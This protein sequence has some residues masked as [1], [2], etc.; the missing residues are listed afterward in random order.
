MTSL[1]LADQS[2]AEAPTDGER[3]TLEQSCASIISEI[4]ANTGLSSLELATL[5][6]ASHFSL[7]RWERGDSVPGPEITNTLTAA[8]ASLRRGEP[9]SRLAPVSAF[10]SRGVRRSTSLPLLDP[11]HRTALTDEPGSPI[12]AR[13]KH[14]AFWGA[15]SL[16]EVLA[17]NASASPTLKEAAA[18]G[19][20]AGKNTY[21][22]DAHTYHTKVPPQGIAEV[23]RQYLPAGGLV[24]DPF[25]GSGMTGVAA[26]AVGYDVVLNELSP[27]ASFIADRFTS[28][29]DPAAFS[30]AVA[31]VIDTLSDVRRELYVTDCREC[32]RET[33]L[34]YTVWSYRVSCPA[35]SDE[36][37]LWDHCRSYGRTVRDHKILKEFPCPSCQAVIKKS[38]LARTDAVPVLVGYKCCKRVQVE[39][40][41]SEADLK[42]IKSIEQGEFLVEGFYPET[43]LPAGVNLSQPCKHGLTSIDR[44]YTSRNLSAMSQLWQAIHKVEDDEIAAFL[45]FIFTSLY[46]RVTRMSEFRFWGGSGNTAHFNVP[47][48]FNEANVFTSFLRKSRT[49]LDHLQ[50][51]AC[52][53]QGRAVIRTGSATDLAFLPDESID[54]VFTDPPFGAN[55]NYSEMN[56]IWEAWLGEF[57]DNRSEAIV[58]KAQ[59]KNIDDY[60][61]LMRDSIAECHRVLRDGHWMLL[62]FMNSSQAIWDCLR[63]AIHDGGFNIEK[64]DIFDKQHGTFKQYVSDNTA[65][66]DL[67]LHCRKSDARS[68]TAAPHLDLESQVDEFIDRRGGTLP[69][70]PFLHVRRDEEVDYRMLYSQFLSEGLLTDASA[71]DFAT[72]RELAAKK[73]RTN[74]Q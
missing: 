55:I 13:I 67:I 68:T 14:G 3:D 74:Q 33:E 38:R 24:L 15:S 32:G 9:I 58:N 12:L 39:H 16:D 40:P 69:K 28:K 63:R 64:I 48:I 50:S 5:L 11:E 18:G 70:M 37:V 65:G 8:A 45:A 41:L 31:T 20:S 4:R 61:R 49:I 23:L 72:F 34:E 43:P 73:I 59:N 52:R 71:A 29:L 21:T 25:A 60:E 42:R 62:V 10:A 27:A 36:F 46:R 66:C 26:R 30:T 6:G 47:Y 57:T 22:Y 17:D 7:V 51:T 35:C 54:L 1:P 56:I 44:F 19:I 2:A 53:Y